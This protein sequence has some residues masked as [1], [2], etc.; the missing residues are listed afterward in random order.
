MALTLQTVLETEIASP[1][2]V[3]FKLRE[4]IED[5]DGTFD[6]ITEIIKSDPGLA[7]RLL[8]IANSSF[9]GLAAKVETIQHALS[10]IGSDQL[11]DLALATSVI[12]RFKGIP[13][14]LVDVG[15]F[16]RHNVAC[17]VAARHI[18]LYKNFE[19]P[20]WYYLAGILHDLGKLILLKEIPDE[21]AKV[22]AEVRENDNLR[23]KDVETRILKFNHVQ[24]GSIL[25]KEWKL[26][27][28]LVGAINYHHDPLKARDHVTEASVVHVADYLAYRIGLTDGCESTSPSLVSQTLTN[29]ALNLKFMKEAKL[30]VEEHTEQIVQ[31]FTSK[32]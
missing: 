25:L 18:A 23:L 15:R 8:K 16:W 3:Y 10:I 4:V 30:T 32:N 9:Y 13:K 11:S 26:P 12:N 1:P 21:Y 29:L 6:Q 17:G 31:A 27:P 14:D 22:L 28:S 2:G 24:V 20:E 19:H 7:A 5:P